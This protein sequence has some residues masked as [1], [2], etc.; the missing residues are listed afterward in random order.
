[1]NDLIVALGLVLVIE[2][3]IWAALPHIGKSMMLTVAETPPATLR[4]AG[5]VAIALGVCIVW[6]VKG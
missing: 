6:L 3:L 5:T 4:M 1:M 2:G